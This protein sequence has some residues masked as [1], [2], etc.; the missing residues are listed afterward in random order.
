[1]QPR[2]NLFLASKY[3]YV[4]GGRP[5]VTC[6]FCGIL[7]G[8]PRVES[9]VVHKTELNFVCLNLYPYSPGHVMVVPNRHVKDPREL[10]DKE[11]REI[12]SLM[13]LSM[14]LLEENLHCQGF[15]LGLNIG[16]AGGASIAHLHWHVVPRYRN[17]TGFIDIIGGSK[18]IIVDPLELQKDLTAAFANTKKRSHAKR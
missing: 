12:Q 6:I 11:E 4:R 10:N 2:K 3:A 16:V 7:A 1:M 18:I 9:L 14:T 5:K 8:D 13:K 15:N 17:E